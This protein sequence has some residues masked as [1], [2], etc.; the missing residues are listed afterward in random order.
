MGNI[1]EKENSCDGL[2]V[3]NKYK[4][5]RGKSYDA[6]CVTQDRR[7]KLLHLKK[8]YSNLNYIDLNGDYA[9]F[10]KQPAQKGFTGGFSA[11]HIEPIQSGNTI[12]LNLNKYVFFKSS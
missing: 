3:E 2:V 9:L 8:R 6:Y 12:N 4:L 10:Y 1:F 11:F 5:V 7:S